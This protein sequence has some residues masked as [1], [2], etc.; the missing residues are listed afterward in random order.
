VD[1]QAAEL[2]TRFRL[3]PVPPFVTGYDSPETVWIGEPLGSIHPGPAD[4]VLYVVNPAIPKSPYATPYLPPYRGSIH[5]P[6][7]PGPDGHFD[8][9]P[10][11]SPGFLAAH[12]YA[13]VRRV[14]DIGQSYL[15]R[16]IRWHFRDTYERLEIIP[17]V[18]WDNAH[19]GYGFLELGAPPIDALEQFPYALNFG[20]VAHEVGHLLLLGELGPPPASEFAP[21]HV[22]DFLS[23]HESIADLVSMLSIIQFDIVLDN[24]LR[25]TRGNLFIANELDRIGIISPESELRNASQ[26]LKVSDVGDDIHDRSRPFTGAIFDSLVEIFQALLYKRGLTGL[27]PYKIRNLRQELRQTELDSVLAD[28]SDRYE[29]QHFAVKSALADAR[30]LVGEALMLSWSWLDPENFDFRLGAEAV[31]RGAESGRASLFVDLIHDN[32]AWRELL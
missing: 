8:H 2:G 9:L 28:S 18:D 19:S 1:G 10:V 7:E 20:I 15:R 5:P 11:D 14:L 30:D 25:R 23:Y 29:L 16:E 6:P 4:A 31:L 21:H 32:F 22:S 17:N 26:S 24:L 27:D 12:A 13:S 3:F